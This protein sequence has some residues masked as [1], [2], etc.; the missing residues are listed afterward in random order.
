LL[1]V[2]C[3]PWSSRFWRRPDYRGLRVRGPTYLE[4]REKIPVP[5]APLFEC[6]AVD[7]FLTEYRIDHIC[8][9][10]KNRIYQSLQRNEKLPFTFVLHIQVPGPPFYSF[11]VYMVANHPEVVR[12]LD[13]DA[14]PNVE[15]SAAFPI[16]M[17]QLLLSFFRTGNDDFCT[18]HFKMIPRIVEGPWIVRAGIVSKP[19][20]IGNKLK[21]SY[22]RAPR[23]FELDIHVGT[24][25]IATTLTQLAASYAKLITVDLAFLIEGKITETLPEFICGLVRCTHPDF[26]Q[27]IPL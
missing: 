2:P 17:K 12:L 6:V 18:S 10:P 7:M 26:K 24:N 11:V 3:P 14:E 4:N 20:L 1:T 5:M 13:P 9:H 21:N 15:L 16:G 22:Y 8:S 19:A 25:S 23:Y 27:A